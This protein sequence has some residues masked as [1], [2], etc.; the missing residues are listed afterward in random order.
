MEKAGRIR[1]F[2]TYVCEASFANPAA[3]I[4]EQEIGER[5]FGK[6]AGYETTQDNIVRVTASQ[7]RKKL[8]QYFTAEGALEPIVLEIPKGQYMPVFRERK[9][10]AGTVS[11]VPA[12]VNR[13]PLYT[14]ASLCVVLLGVIVVLAIQLR[15]DRS[16]TPGA[17]P[18]LNALWGQMLPANGRTAL[19]VTDSSLSFFQE[20]LSRQLSLA[21]YLKPDTWTKGAGM[22]GNPELQEF[23]QRAVQHRF[24][25]LANVTIAYR[26]AR[27]GGNRLS[28]FSA[29]DFNIRQMQSDNVIL[30]GSPR[31]NPWVELISERLNFRYAFDQTLRYSYFE[32]RAPKPGE[33][34]V[35]RSDSGTSLCQIALV[36]NLNRTGSILII[37]GTEVEGT[38]AGGEFLTDEHSVAQLTSALGRQSGKLPYFEV[39]LKGSRLGGLARR[40]EIIYARPLRN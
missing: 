4:H 16:G 39:L 29:R 32:N 18:N 36:P 40:F 3:D 30:L 24:T 10:D 25:S 31:A 12:P 7:A 8:D 20:L 28:L 33:P 19:V 26:L 35:Y 9:L 1:E 23:A 14:L 21:E 13:R 34:K 5:V 2:L 15:S 22:E 17:S 37:A 38:E 11:L 27:L 6:P